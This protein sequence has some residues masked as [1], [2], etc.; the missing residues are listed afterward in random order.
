[1]DNTEPTTI[2]STE[3]AFSKC[4]MFLACMESI[5]DGDN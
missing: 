2:I 5:F 4:E 1:M 3:R